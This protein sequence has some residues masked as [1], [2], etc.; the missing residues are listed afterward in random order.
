MVLFNVLHVWHL[1]RHSWNFAKNNDNLEHTRYQSGH[2]SQYC[3]AKENTWLL[4]LHLFP[5]NPL[6]AMASPST[7][8]PEDIHL[9]RS[10]QWR[11]HVPRLLVLS[12]KWSRTRNSIH[13][14][15]M[16]WVSMIPPCPITIGWTSE[17]ASR[18]RRVLVITIYRLIRQDLPAEIHM[19]ISVRQLKVG[20]MLLPL[21]WH[22]SLVLKEVGVYGLHW[23]FMV[24]YL[25]PVTSESVHQ[26]SVEF[27]PGDESE[28]N[29]LLCVKHTRCPLI[30]TFL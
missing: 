26:T 8:L 10:S 15:L 7:A 17:Q 12:R 20:R 1:S 23:L 18:C 5:S 28:I 30:S 27:T 9:I 2:A 19:H 22:W 11:S 13:S 3:T 25:C 24:L 16:S 6:S 21:T 29:G 4:L 14:L